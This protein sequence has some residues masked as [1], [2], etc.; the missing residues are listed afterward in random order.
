[1][2]H[3][4][5]IASDS[6][7]IAS[8]GSNRWRRW[9]ENHHVPRDMHCLVNDRISW[10]LAH[11]QVDNQTTRLMLCL[12][13]TAHVCL[14]EARR[15]A[16]PKAEVYYRDWQPHSQASAARGRS[17]W[18]DQVCWWFAITAEA[19][20]LNWPS[21][22][23]AIT[24][25]RDGPQPCNTSNTT[26]QS[27]KQKGGKLFVAQNTPQQTFLNLISLSV[28]TLLE[29]QFTWKLAE[30]LQRTYQLLISIN[31]NDMK[32]IKDYFIRHDFGLFTEVFVNSYKVIGWFNFQIFN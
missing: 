19:K 11:V 27:A 32:W 10:W 28:W 13:V 23:L 14:E 18:T 17:H 26:W 7:T 6:L 29:S 12:T 1:M 9:R 30:E 4:T 3:E 31:C 5:C 20:S 25:E 2:C 24:A 15:R 16:V 22:W 8:V 21:W